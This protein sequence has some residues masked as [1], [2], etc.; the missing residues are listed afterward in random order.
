MSSYVFDSDSLFDVLWESPRVRFGIFE[1]RLGEPDGGIEGR[2]PTWPTLAF[3]RATVRMRSLPGREAAIADA[4]TAVLLAPERR[5]RVHGI[6]C[7]RVMATF[8]QVHP[9][10]LMELVTEAGASTVEDVEELFA[11]SP[12]VTDFDVLALQRLVLQHVQRSPSPDERFVKQALRRILEST[13]KGLA[14]A[15]SRPGAPCSQS[16]WLAER[17]REVLARRYRENTSVRELAEEVGC[18]VFHLCRVFRIETGLTLHQY[19]HRLR[20]AA[21]LSRVVR[22]DDLSSVA[23]D[24]GYASHSHFTERF[25]TAFGLTPSRYRECAASSL[26]VKTVV[27]HSL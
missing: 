23:C 20:L 7:S 27:Q 10:F 24:L 4:A 1:A 2:V 9:D 8:L 26:S 15:R 16:R 3:P 17:A 22:G 14:G 19:R 6:G 12:R 5:L 21:S 25:R 11:R 13:M 18:S